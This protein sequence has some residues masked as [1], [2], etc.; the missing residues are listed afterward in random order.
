[1]NALKPRVLGPDGLPVH[2]PESRKSPGLPSPSR[3]LVLRGLGGAALALPFLE[4][5][6][7]AGATPS[8]GPFYAVFLREGN[9]VAQADYNGEPDMFWPRET[10]SITQSSLSTTD[11]DRAV[12]ELSG[13]ADRMLLVKGTRFA[14]TDNVTCGH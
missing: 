13:Y 3:R 7:P 1:M 9:G 5:W 12:S 11:A 2:A 6:R 8:P 14:F 10:G 4:S